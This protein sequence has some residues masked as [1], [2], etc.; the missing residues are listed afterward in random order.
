MSSA[1]THSRNR[2]MILFPRI[3]ASSILLM[4]AGTPCLARSSNNYCSCLLAAPLDAAGRRDGAYGVSIVVPER[5]KKSFENHDE[6]WGVQWKDR[7]SLISYYYY[8]LSMSD[9][10]SY[11]HPGKDECALEVNH[12]RVL[13]ENYDRKL[14]GNG[15]FANFEMAIPKGAGFGMTV[16]ASDRQTV[17]SLAAKAMW[18]AVFGP[19]TLDG[20]KILS[21]SPDR[22]WFRYEN[23]PGVVMKARIGDRIHSQDSK[24]TAISDS[25]ITITEPQPDGR[26]GWNMVGRVLPLEKAINAK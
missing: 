18:S 25:S 17:C 4:S 14:K 10:I 19:R 3:L 24:V 7:K 6:F 16:S 26:G 12:R 15:L 11:E 20:L 1:G 8:P 23:A 21:I 22:K 13:I 9:P 5:A 2:S